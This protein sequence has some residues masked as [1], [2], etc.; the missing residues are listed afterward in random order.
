[1]DNSK[2][3]AAALERAKEVAD[4]YD[5]HIVRSSD[6]S[7]T[8]REI[9]LRNNWLQ[10]IIK[11]WYMLT[12][13]DVKPGDST[14]WY[15]NF[16]N[17]VA[18][19]LNQRYND[20]YCLSAEHSIALHNETSV[21]PK[22]VIAMVPSSTGVQKLPF[23]SSILMYTQK[24]IPKE[25][26]KVHNIQVMPLPLALCKV[27]PTY[28]RNNEDEVEVALRAIRTVTDLARIIIKYNSTRAASRILGAYISLNMH[29]EAEELKKLLNK[30][31]IHVTPTFIIEK[32]Q[33]KILLQ[34]PSPYAARIKVLWNKQR[35][36]V[37]QIFP[38]APGIPKNQNKYLKKVEHLYEQDAY[39]SLS[40]EGYQVTEALIIRVKN[41]NWNPDLNEQDNSQR[42]ALAAR[43]YYDAFQSV[44]ETIKT[45]FTGE[46]P[47]EI[48]KKALP[49]WYQNL[50]GPSVQ[51]QIIP[52]SA[53]IGYRNDRVYIR[54]SKH[55]P[56]AKEAILDAMDA[57]F[58]CL[59]EE[60]EASVRAVLG[61][62][63]FANIHPYMDGNGRI[64]RFLLNLMLA[65][66]GY[67]WTIIE[68][69][70][71]D[72][73]IDALEHAH[74]TK[75]IQPFAKFVLDEMKSA[76]PL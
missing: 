16:W 20:T 41:N 42:N 44:K 27:T 74:T 31:G 36:N 21:I 15:A 72:A 32:E 34:A 1:M 60:P 13:P 37:L 46:N 61:H 43:G 52:A 4:R 28:F 53:L 64:A 75:D 54:N 73:Y 6:L 39:N 63:I 57:L 35:Q 23:D 25:R 70:Q 62:Y 8:D 7:R 22:Q 48:F 40:I 33:T 18:V 17:F 5:S 3:I 19:Y 38:K 9:L 59:S 65:S 2:K 51:A 14:A 12:R 76:Q 30:S 58:D 45:I 10:D 55:V 50:F 11:G 29:D 47:G 66:G 69:K 68:V 71:R 56:P 24:S 26:I 49:E 67:P